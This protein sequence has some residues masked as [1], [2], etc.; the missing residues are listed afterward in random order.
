MSAVALLRSRTT[1]GCATSSSRHGAFAIQASATRPFSSCLPHPFPSCP[2]SVAQAHLHNLWQPAHPH[3]AQLCTLRA[4]ATLVASKVVCH[5]L[6]TLVSSAAPIPRLVPPRLL[7]TS[8][9]R[10]AAAYLPACP[11]QRAVARR[12]GPRNPIVHPRT[13][14]GCGDGVWMWPRTSLTCARGWS[15]QSSRVYLLRVIGTTSV[16][17]APVGQSVAC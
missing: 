4:A 5:V 9:F 7:A 6:S 10:M 15:T 11:R 13:S 12:N 16:N 17:R 3:K 2:L 14:H 1:S 8:G